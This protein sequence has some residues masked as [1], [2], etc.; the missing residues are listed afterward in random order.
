[1]EDRRHEFFYHSQAAQWTQTGDRVF[2]EF[3]EVAGPR[4]QRAGVWQLKK[5]NGTLAVE[6][7]KLRKVATNFNRDLLTADPP[8]ESLDACRNQVWSHVQRRVSD[9]MRQ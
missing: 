9:A 2:G 6:P 4:H 5:P 7:N 8:L 3:F 1:M